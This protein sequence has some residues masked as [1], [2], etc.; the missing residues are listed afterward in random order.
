MQ[1]QIIQNLSCMT[2]RCACG[3]LRGNKNN[4]DNVRGSDAADAV[5]GA[6]SSSGNALAAPADTQQAVPPDNA[7]EAAAATSSQGGN[8][9]QHTAQQNK[10][11]RKL[12]SS[13]TEVRKA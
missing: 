10:A 12:A 9:K 5:M 3:M 2:L 8:A 11:K 7:A 1:M 6:G 4:N 13:D